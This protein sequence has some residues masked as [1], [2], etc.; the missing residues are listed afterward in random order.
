LCVKRISTT[1]YGL[2]SYIGDYIGALANR[3]HQI[4]QMKNL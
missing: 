1:E 2:Q 3:I 4:L